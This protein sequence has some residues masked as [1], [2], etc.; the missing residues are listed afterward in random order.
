MPPRFP[1]LNVNSSAQKWLRSVRNLGLGVSP[2]I[3]LLTTLRLQSPFP[4][5]SSEMEYVAA[6][7]YS[8]SP[9]QIARFSFPG[10]EGTPKFHFQDFIVREVLAPQPSQPLVALVYMPLACCKTSLAFSRRHKALS[11][12]ALEVKSA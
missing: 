12:L 11:L 10:A 6:L 8:Y 4:I 7:L 1:S 9:F 2:I 3:M 5:T